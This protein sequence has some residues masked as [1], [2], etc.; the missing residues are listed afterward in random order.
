MV[1]SHLLDTNVVI[2][3]L[4]GEADV[5]RAMLRSTPGS[6]AFSA[7][8]VHELERGLQRQGAPMAKRQALDAVIAA[9]TVL[10]LDASVARRSGAIDAVLWS[11]G[12]QIG[13]YDVLIAATAM[14]Y[15]LTLITNNVREF[16]RIPSLSIENWRIN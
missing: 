2:D 8:S 12:E 16:M 10:P 14:H 6:L 13:P 4:R 1:I 15:K 11:S 5:V 7:I 9:F 3:Y